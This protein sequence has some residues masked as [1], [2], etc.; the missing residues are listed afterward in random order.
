M[1]PD[2]R[3][4]VLTELK[5]V[6]AVETDISC[7][8]TNMIGKAKSVCGNCGLAQS[9]QEAVQQGKTVWQ[10]GRLGRL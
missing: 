1:A 6:L 3:R 8:K 7:L 4:Q 10:L 2:N 9:L 5:N